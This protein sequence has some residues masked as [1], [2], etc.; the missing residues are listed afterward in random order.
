MNSL[1]MAYVVYDGDGA[2]AFT[3][4]LYQWYLRDFDI[5]Y[6]VESVYPHLDKA[7]CVCVDKCS[8]NIHDFNDDSWSQYLPSVSHL[9]ADEAISANMR[10][11]E[12][13]V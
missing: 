11:R 1:T 8:V 12:A 13:N 6:F 2:I 3:G 5:N 9:I 4:P 7:F 10:L